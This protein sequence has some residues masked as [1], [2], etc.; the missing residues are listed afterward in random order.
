M[1]DTPDANVALESTVLE[2]NHYM[3]NMFP[4]PIVYMLL[5]E[6]IDPVLTSIVT[7]EVVYDYRCLTKQVRRKGLDDMKRI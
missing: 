5:G 4:F 1:R 7:R 6:H 3:R 2:V